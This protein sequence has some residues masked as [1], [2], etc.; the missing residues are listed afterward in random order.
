MIAPGGT[1]EQHQAV[2]YPA[3]PGRCP[4]LF[5]R[6]HGFV[7]P[8]KALDASLL[9]GATVIATACGLDIRHR[10][11]SQVIDQPQAK[12][13][14]EL[15][16]FMLRSVVIANEYLTAVEDQGKHVTLDELNKAAAELET[17]T[18]TW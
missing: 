7:L 16:N 2:G 3:E 5:V 6:R 11:W 13:E 17:F 15:A 8:S 1:T 4:T 14:E 9:S 12:T 10:L 18:R